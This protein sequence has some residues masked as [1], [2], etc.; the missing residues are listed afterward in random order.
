V[1]IDALRKDRTSHAKE[2]DALLERNDQ[3][4]HALTLKGTPG[5]VIGRQ[6]LPGVTDLNTLKQLVAKA[7]HSQ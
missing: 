1:N 3:E 4:A 5:L 6:L 7:R 2:I